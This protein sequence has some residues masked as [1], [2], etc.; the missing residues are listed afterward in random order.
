MYQSFKHS[1][2]EKVHNDTVINTLNDYFIHARNV[3][4]ERYLFHTKYQIEE[5]TVEDFETSLHKGVQGYN[6]PAEFQDEAI[7]QQ[8]VGK[9]IKIYLKD[10]NWTQI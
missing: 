1:E 10:N 5:E 2:T 3:I 7:R 6:F 9:E 8:V 4:Y